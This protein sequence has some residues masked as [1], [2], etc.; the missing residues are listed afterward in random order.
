MIKIVR[1]PRIVAQNPRIVI[2]TPPPIDE[3]R[4]F[5]LDQTKGFTAPRRSAENTR[6]YADMVRTVAEEELGVPIVDLWMKCMEHC[7]WQE[8]EPLP[9]SQD[10]D[11]NPAFLELFTDGEF[12]NLLTRAIP[13]EAIY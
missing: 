6:K 13:T 3:R 2:F 12:L 1:D 8:G 4:Q 10:I 11:E 9:G 5:A 7:G